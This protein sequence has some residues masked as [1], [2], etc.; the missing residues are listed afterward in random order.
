MNEKLKEYIEKIFED[1]PK[2]KRASDLKEEIISNLIDKYNDLVKSGKSNEESYN[3]AI[4]NIGDVSEL[5]NNLRES[6]VLSSAYEEKHRKK[7]AV[8]MSVAVGLYIFSIIPV[9]IFSSLNNEFL[10]ILGVV[11]MFVFAGVATMLL[12]YNSASKP[13]YKGVDSTMVEEF[14]EWKSDNEKKH[15]KLFSIKVAMWA[16]II[17]IYFIF[18]FTFMSWSFSWIIFIV[19]I[20]ISNILDAIFGK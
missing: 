10:D 7:S 9:L 18:S 14:K 15:S 16:M 8:L 19:G 3:I 20:A 2:T 1:V 12:V 11:A 6:D 5:V 13:K 4:S 17:V